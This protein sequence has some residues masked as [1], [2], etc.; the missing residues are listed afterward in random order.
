MRTVLNRVGCAVGGV[1]TEAALAG[2]LEEKVHD[3]AGPVIGRV[4][5]AALLESC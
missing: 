4:P 3:L 5:V 1:G 2:A